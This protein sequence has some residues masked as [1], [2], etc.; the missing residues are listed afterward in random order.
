V[1][2]LIDVCGLPMKLARNGA[3]RGV[4]TRPVSR[5][6]SHHGGGSHSNGTCSACGVLLTPENTSSAAPWCCAC[7]IEDQR[8]DLGQTPKVYQVAEQFHT[9]PCGC[10]G[11]LPK[12]GE[13]N[14]FVSWRNSHKR[15]LGCWVC[16][17]WAILNTSRFDA[18][19]GGYIAIDADTPHHL[20]RRLMDEPLCE[21]CE[22]PLEWVIARGTTPHL[23]HNHDTGEIHGFTHN[24]CNF[25]AMEIEISKLRARN[26]ELEARVFE[27]EMRN[28]VQS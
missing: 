2:S 15:A 5:N 3:D 24:R 8:M 22:Q 1:S 4:C 16:R 7:K 6:G 21:R 23:H 17:V 12:E 14:K 9:L 25:R 18:R 19:E 13:S 11:V 26:H 28:R 10:S 27:L 20:I